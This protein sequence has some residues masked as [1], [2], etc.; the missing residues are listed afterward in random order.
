M[1]S[2]RGLTFA[3]CLVPIVVTGGAVLAQAL[4]ANDAPEAGLPRFVTSDFGGVT[5]ATLETNALP[6]K[7]VATALLLREEHARGV[8][9]GRADL[10]A[11]YRQF[12]FIT[13]ARVANWP[14]SV[15]QP[16]F[17][18]PIGTV[19]RELRGPTSLVRIDAANLG[20]A[21]C[22]AGVTYD[23][24]GRPITNVAWGGMPN[25]SI[26]LEAY[27]QAVFLA[28]ASAVQDR[29]AF[30]ARIAELFPEMGRSERFTLRYLLLPRV[31]KR[32]AQLRD[33]DNGVVPYSNGGAGRTN[34][35]ATL[36]LMLGVPVGRETGHTLHGDVGFT[37]IPDLSGLALRTSLL[38]DGI[39][40][41]I[42]ATRFGQPL[43]RS[44]VTPAHVDSLSDIAGFFTVSTMGV[45]PDASERVLPQ[46]RPA[47]RWLATQYASPRFPG[48]IDSTRMRAGEAVFIA[49]C[50]RCHGTYDNE[51]PRRLVSFPNRLVSGSAIGTDSARWAMVDSS[52]LAQLASSAYGRHMTSMHTG[53]YVPPILNGVWA[54]APYLHNGS[55][56]TI[57]QLLTPS[58]RPTRFLVG[59]HALDFAQLGIAGVRW[60]D[61]TYRYPAGYVPWS[62]PELVDTRD[63]GLSNRGHE[64]Q[65]S[66]LTRDEKLALIEYLKTL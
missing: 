22:H 25:T 39:Y 27:T 64:R 65:V 28:L 16:H 15:P 20:C 8:R 19:S 40:A 5:K 2:A 59:G 58:E 4:S 3:L 45:Q 57:W 33:A 42:G 14:S 34:G 6:Y 43:D 56:P 31:A 60:S 54:T 38:Y 62:I 7:V 37:S 48:P 9:L 52:M 61:D 11:I 46:I 1:S 17:A 29:G 35:V 50:A 12:G 10:P 30:R 66:G 51:T 53:G 18:R 49:R 44:A 26:N 21:T 24:T 13:P 41:P 55:V 32:I 63:P 47:F 36:K 23:S